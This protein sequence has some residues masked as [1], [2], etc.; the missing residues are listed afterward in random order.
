[1]AHQTA[2]DKRKIAKDL[3]VMRNCSGHVEVN[4]GETNWMQQVIY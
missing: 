4:E 1:M 3:K 2:H